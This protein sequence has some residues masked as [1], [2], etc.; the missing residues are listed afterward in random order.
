MYIPKYFEINNEETIYEMIEKNGF[1]TFFSQ[2]NGRPYATHL[3][4]TLDREN[5]ILYGHF[6]RANG[7]WKDI[8]NQEILAVFQGPHCYISPSWYETNK[9][10]PTWNYVVVHVY[11][12]IEFIEEEVLVKSLN[13]LVNNYENPNSSYKLAEVDPQYLEGLNKG[14]VGFKLN[15]NSMECAGKLSQ[16]HPIERQELIIQ[17]LQ[18]INSEDTRKIACMMKDNLRKSP[19]ERK[20][21]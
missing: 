7:Q 3:P 5:S 8:N 6:A 20:K 18:Q 2:H 10:V 17:H 9:A 12:Q 1:A 15:I 11:G 16:N 13:D 19:D 14:I 4:L 21:K